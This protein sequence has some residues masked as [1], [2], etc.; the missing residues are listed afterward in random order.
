MPFYSLARIVAFV[1]AAVFSGQGPVNQDVDFRNFTYPFPAEE[2]LEVPGH[3]AWMSMNVKNAVTLVNG[4]YDFEKTNPPGPTL[5][6]HR[7]EYGYLT[8]EKQLDAVVVL[9]YERGGTASWDYVYAFSFTSGSPKLVGWFQTGRGAYFG[10][11]RLQIENSFLDLIVDLFDPD[12]QMGLSCSEGFVR[13]KYSFRNGY[14]VQS[15]R[16][17]FGTVEKSKPRLAGTH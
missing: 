6:L 1:S 16:E 15:G 13:I 11:Y 5:L 3:M 10:L 8:S 7:V 4:R 9:D 12:R 2:R 17:E 14:F